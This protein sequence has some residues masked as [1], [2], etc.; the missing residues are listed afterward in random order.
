MLYENGWGV[1]KSNS[2]AISWY[3]RA[4]ATGNISIKSIAEAKLKRLRSSQE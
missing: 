4:I 3:E 2:S 1:V